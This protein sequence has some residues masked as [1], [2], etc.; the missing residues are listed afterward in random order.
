MKVK[1]NQGTLSKRY[2]CTLSK[3]DFAFLFPGIYEAELISGDE[4]ILEK[5]GHPK[6]YLPI[7]LVEEKVTRGIITFLDVDKCWMGMKP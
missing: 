1:V 4:L 3:N 6:T 5:N 7:N 2:S